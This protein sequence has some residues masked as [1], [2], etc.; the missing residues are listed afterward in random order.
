MSVINFGESELFVEFQFKRVCEFNFIT[1]LVPFD[2]LELFAWPSGR[3]CL[4]DLTR[5]VLAVNR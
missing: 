3:D 4:D 5:D 2:F 1:V